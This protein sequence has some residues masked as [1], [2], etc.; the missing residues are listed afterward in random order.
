MKEKKL[1]RRILFFLV[2]LILSITL[3]PSLTYAQDTSPEKE[4][5]K[6]ERVEW[7]G[8]KV[9]LGGIPL[10][11]IKGLGSWRVIRG[12]EYFLGFYIYSTSPYFRLNGDNQTIFRGLGRENDLLQVF[13]PTFCP[14]D[15]LRNIL[16]SVPKARN[17]LEKFDEQRSTAESFYM[18]GNFL[19]YGGQ[20]ATIGGIIGAY[21]SVFTMDPHYN[22][23]LTIAKIGAGAYILGKMIEF[24]SETLGEKAFLHLDDAIHYFNEAHSKISSHNSSVSLAI[25]VENNRVIPGI[26]YNF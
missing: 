13:L 11:R 26:R 25:K 5:W 21:A 24:Y 4:V 9:E 8:L 12:K 23:Y 22:T 14:R 3:T 10:L 7:S 16:N 6:I 17:S 2:G 1:T 19:D 15:K 20:I 18:I